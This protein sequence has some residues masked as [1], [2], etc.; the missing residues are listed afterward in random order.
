MKFSDIENYFDIVKSNKSYLYTC[1]R[2]HKIL[3]AGEVLNFNDYPWGDV[4]N[5]FENVNGFQNIIL[6]NI[7][8]L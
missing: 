3:P 2:Y 7:P 6:L 8:F 1:N 4:K 5:I